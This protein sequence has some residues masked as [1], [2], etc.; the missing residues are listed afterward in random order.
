MITG[1][2]GAWRACFFLYPFLTSRTQNK[3]EKTFFPRNFLH[4]MA[5]GGE[6]TRSDLYLLPRFWPR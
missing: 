1:L 4:R 3:K 2:E 6:R 5:H